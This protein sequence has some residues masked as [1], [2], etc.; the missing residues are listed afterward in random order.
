V[1]WTQEAIKAGASVDD[2]AALINQR[3]FVSGKY[4]G[5]QPQLYRI[6]QA[7]QNIYDEVKGPPV[8]R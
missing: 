5:Y 8:K 6:K 3:L 1:T 2:A 7:V 4:T